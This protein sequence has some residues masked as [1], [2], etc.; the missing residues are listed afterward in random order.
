VF[1]VDVMTACRDNDNNNNNMV[2][3]SLC[4]AMRSVRFARYPIFFQAG[5]YGMHLSHCLCYRL[6]NLGSPPTH[7]ESLDV[8]CCRNCYSHSP[9]YSFSIRNIR[10]S[11]CRDRVVP[12]ARVYINDGGF[13]YTIEFKICGKRLS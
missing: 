8:K 12:K 13:Y 1:L 9:L 7:L 10:S 3:V 4:F 2:R 6:S 5:V 11:Q